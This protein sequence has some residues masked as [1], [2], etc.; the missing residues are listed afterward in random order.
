MKIKKI[1]YSTLSRDNYL[2]TLQRSYFIL[3]RL[4]VLKFS[5]KYAYHYFVKKLIN[6]GDTILDIGAN[7]GYYSILFARWVGKKGRVYAVEPVSVYNTI[8]NELAKKHGNITL[9]P[10]ALGNIEKEVELVSVVS[11]GYLRTGLS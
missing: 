9:Y 8:F 7:L 5:P 10:Y 3:Y 2:R 6:K 1:L 4:G 11:S